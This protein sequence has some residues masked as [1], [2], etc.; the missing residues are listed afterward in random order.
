MTAPD[1]PPALVAR[2]RPVG[3]LGQ[4]AFGV[5]VRATPLAGG[6]DVAIKLLLDQ[7]DP[8]LVARFDREARATAS[9]DHPHVVKVLEHATGEGAQGGAYIVYEWVDGEDLER[10]AKG[11]GAADRLARWARQVADALAAA[12]RV[13]LVHRDIKPENVLVDRAGFAK[14]V[15]FGVARKAEGRTIQTGTGVLLGTPAFMAPELF[16]GQRAGPASDQWAWAATFVT[17]ATGQTPYR[18]M[19]PGSMVQDALSDRPLDEDLGRVALAPGFA[20]ALRRGLARDPGAR[21]ED[22]QAAVDALDLVL[23]GTGGGE[24]LATVAAPEDGGGHRTDPATEPPARARPMQ[25]QAPATPAPPIPSSR[26]GPLAALALVVALGLG[27]ASSSGTQPAAAPTEAPSPAPPPPA[28]TAPSPAEDEATRRSHLI[29]VLGFVEGQVLE[30]DLRDRHDPRR[31]RKLEDWTLGRGPDF[32][33]SWTEVMDALAAWLV[34]ARVAGV[35]RP[36]APGYDAVART[37]LL[38]MRKRFVW[39]LDGVRVLEMSSASPR[40]AFFD[41]DV[42]RYSGLLERTPGFAKDCRAAARVVQDA[43]RDAPGEVSSA[44]LDLAINL[45]SWDP[46]AEAERE[47]RRLADAVEA[48]L[49]RPGASGVVHAMTALLNRVDSLA[50]LSCEVRAEVAG[51]VARWILH[52]LPVT[53]S[54]HHRY[55]SLAGALFFQTRTCR[56]AYVEARQADVE[57]VTR[58]LREAAAAG[59][60]DRLTRQSLRWSFGGEAVMRQNTAPAWQPYR[61]RLLELVSQ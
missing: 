37:L 32:L 49:D 11:G 52:D 57:E 5:V 43:L 2:Y 26:R 24:L 54:T 40:D 46:P 18:G 42:K 28:A 19:D 1:L 47:L 33:A 60:L 30:T 13:G 53:A 7:H 61:D 44:E 4:G 14:V 27:W 31:A 3:V 20:A 36:D 38:D 12:H 22:M 35:L 48:A 34:A 6:P 50:R 56:E 17:L 55:A 39:V 23:A 10:A 8:E 58:R 9:L 29:E 25:A 15:D 59:P 41:P 45:Y 16:R 21:F 51:R